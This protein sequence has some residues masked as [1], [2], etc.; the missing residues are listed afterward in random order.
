MRGSKT[1]EER[2]IGNAKIFTPSER[3]A[4]LKQPYGQYDPAELTAPYYAHVQHLSDTTKMQYIDVNF[5]L[6]GDILLKADKM[7]MANSLEVRVPFLDKEVFKVASS[8]PVKYKVNSENTKYAMR[9]AAHR[10]LPSLVAEKKKLGFPVPI[11]I[12]L[13]E[14]RYYNKVRRMFT[15]ERAGQFFRTIELV[16]ML[17]EHRAGKQDLSRKIW[18]VYMFLVW[19]KVYFG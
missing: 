5:W 1:V 19:H 13:R 18:V 2:F 16:R 11:R 10:H 9:R 17:D 15:S 6:V 3:E 14:E 4:I 7:S 12:W 8:I